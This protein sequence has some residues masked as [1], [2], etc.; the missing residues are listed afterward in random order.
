MQHKKCAI[1]RFRVNWTFLVTCYNMLWMSYIRA[2]LCYIR[3]M[4][5]CFRKAWFAGSSP[6]TGSR[7]RAVRYGER[8]CLRLDSVSAP[9][10][11]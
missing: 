4:L 2:Y 10:V 11:R 1:E 7:L 5:E 6:A 9:I 8:A 3:A